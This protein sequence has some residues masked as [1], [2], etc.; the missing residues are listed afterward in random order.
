MSRPRLCAPALAALA[1]AAGCATAPATPAPSAAAPSASPAGASAAAPAPAWRRSPPPVAIPAPAPPAPVVREG[2]LPDGVRVVVVEHPGRPVVELRLILPLGSLADP[3]E[4]AGATRLAALI[5]TDQYELALNGEELHGERSFRR[6]VIDLGGVADVEVGPDATVFALSGYAEDT[7]RYL[8]MLGEALARPR[9]G[10][11]SFRG[12]REATLNALE[13]LESSD[14]EALHQMIAQAAFGKGHPYARPV[15]GTTASLGPMGLE[16]VIRQQE[17]LLV[18]AG[19]TLLVVGAVDGRRVLADARAAFA[20]WTGKRGTTAGPVPPP[21]VPAGE[22]AVG[23]LRRQPA[24]TLLT[25]ATRPLSDVAGS[26]AALDVLATVLAGGAGGRLHAA[27]REEAGLTYTVFA[28]VVRHRRARA[29]LACTPLRADAADRGVRLLRQALEDLRTAGPSADEVERARG[30]RLAEL[31]AA[32]ADVAGLTRSWEEA[33]VLGE[34]RPRPGR[35]R[36][37]LAAVTTAQVRE[38]ART[39]LR[40][41][42]LRWILSG[43]PAAAARATAANGLGVVAPLQPQR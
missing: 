27:L 43:E 11:Q 41:G 24:S 9:N 7:A 33:I 14:G 40:P 35:R 34:D 21:A 4:S 17:Q 12:R 3:P 16:D 37:E 13:D 22:R 29:L 18:P 1:L 10:E 6:Q 36:A 5:A 30:V 31:D 20:R 26:D 8:A 25:C 23:L 38:L 15:Y 32:A 39:V 2:Q 28:A 42:S 19:A